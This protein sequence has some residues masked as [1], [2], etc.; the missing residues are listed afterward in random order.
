MKPVLYG[1]TKAIT[2]PL[3]GK[4]YMTKDAGEKPL[5]VGDQVTKG[6]I[7]CYIEAMKVTNAVKADQEGT[8]VD[9]LIGEGDDV[10]DDD[11]LIKLS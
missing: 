4:I 3:E 6:D 10:F 9:I 1:S 8:V 11:V 5:K 7:V 2:A